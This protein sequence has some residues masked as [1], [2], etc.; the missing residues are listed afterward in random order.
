MIL[1]APVRVLDEPTEVCYWVEVRSRYREYGPGF[2]G[3]SS[4]QKVAIGTA[5]SLIIGEMSLLCQPPLPSTNVA[6]RGPLRGSSFGI[7]ELESAVEQ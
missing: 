1:P 5:G 7:L 4:N 3:V 6:R 2:Q